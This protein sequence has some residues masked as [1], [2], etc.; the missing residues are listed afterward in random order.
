[1]RGAGTGGCPPSRVCVVNG[2]GRLSPSCV[3]RAAGGLTSLSERLSDLGGFDPLQRNAAEVQALHL[4]L[5][6]Q[7]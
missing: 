6:E 1:M 3:E 5:P 4:A 7:T 2:R